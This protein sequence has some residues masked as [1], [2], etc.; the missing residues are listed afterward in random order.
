MIDPATLFASFFAKKVSRLYMYRS[1]RLLQEK[2]QRT[3]ALRLSSALMEA[4]DEAQYTV[5]AEKPFRLMAFI[6]FIL[7]KCFPI[8]LGG[9]VCFV[10]AVA[11]YQIS[12]PK[13]QATSKLYILENN[14]TSVDM[15]A[16]Q[17]STLLISDYREVLK[18]WEVHEAV[19]SQFGLDMT[20]HEMQDMLHVQIP[21]GSRL[22]YITIHHTDPALAANLANAYAEAAHAYIV[23]EL[24]GMQPNIFSSAIIPSHISGLPLSL[25]LLLAWIAGLG[26]MCVF[27][28]VFFCLD[29]HVRTPEDL[30]L[31]SGAPVIGV[32]PQR[33][34]KQIQIAEKEKACLIAARLRT[35]GA[36]CV[37][38]SAPHSR[39]G[40]SH[41]CESLA[42]ALRELHC[43]PLWLRIEHT[44]YADH[45][46]QYTLKDF[47]EERCSYKEL[48]Q[49]NE[50]ALTIRGTEADLPSQLFHPRM[51]VLM[52]KLRDDYD[53][54]LVDVPPVHQHADGSAFFQFCDG[55]ILI[56]SNGK[57]RLD[58]VRSYADLLADSRLPL[59][60]SI[61]NNVH[62]KQKH[63][64]PAVSSAK[65]SVDA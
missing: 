30:T 25:R 37:L 42:L 62:G 20:Y 2:Q 59:L 32:F 14:G 19:R 10:L 11:F 51:A 6:R 4:I 49:I 60:G 7:S 56:A 45:S 23:E 21:S 50:S 24:H 57:D 38:I 54:I 35:S 31:A 65:A 5:S 15:Y 18:T 63:I 39:E 41:V 61:L 43:Q 53:I 58:D 12:P 8:L 26:M 48:L 47:L 17:A 29:D 13:Y 40:V 27:Y 9:F 16:L 1:N 64:R 44:P 55:C 36:H 52:Q 34:G 22:I 46:N 33:C 28:A 3:T